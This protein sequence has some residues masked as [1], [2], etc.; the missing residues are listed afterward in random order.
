LLDASE[1]AESGYEVNVV[2]L[3]DLLSLSDRRLAIKI[4]VENYECNVLVGMQRTLR[5][6]EC[7]I[8]VESFDTLDQVASL[9]TAAG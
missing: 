9:L 2:R 4:D 5:Q 6:N 8:Q 1:A 3:D 7:M